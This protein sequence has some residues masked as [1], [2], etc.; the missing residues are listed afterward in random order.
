[1]GFTPAL[2][3]R[4]VD[5]CFKLYE[6]HSPDLPSHVLPVQFKLEY[7]ITSHFQFKR[8]NSFADYVFGG[9][10]SSWHLD[11]RQKLKIVACEHHLQ[12]ATNLKIM[13]EIV[14][15]Y[16]VQRLKVAIYYFQLPKHFV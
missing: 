13:E 15:L 5:T 4:P 10:L 14:K 16:R 2:Q 3:V 6:P 9:G 11:L 8:P 1:M 7:I 12:L